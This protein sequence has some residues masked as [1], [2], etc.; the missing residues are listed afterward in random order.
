MCL[1]DCVA[2]WDPERIR[3]VGVSHRDPANPLRANGR[4][5]IACG[6]EY[7]AQAMAV[8]G[9]LV[10]A[11]S[12]APPGRTPSAGFLAGVRGVRPY[13]RRLDDIAGE[14][15]CDAVRAAGDGSSALYDFT[16]SADGKPLLRGRAT[17][18][19]DAGDGGES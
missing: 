16:L 8:H 15:V 12:P 5:G 7:A 14:L 17:V 2:H 1:L 3:C 11:G 18:V 6:I 10:S 19:L 9:S 13:V 4:L